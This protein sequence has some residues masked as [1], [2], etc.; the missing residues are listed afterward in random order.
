MY[1]AMHV[2]KYVWHIATALVAPVQFL[3]QPLDLNSEQ[4]P[5]IKLFVMAQVALMEQG[6]NRKTA[7]KLVEEHF[8]KSAPK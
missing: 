3:Q 8:R 6:H 4:P 2:D 7:Y 1:T 5:A